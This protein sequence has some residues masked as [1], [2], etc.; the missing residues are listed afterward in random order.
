[1]TDGRKCARW[2]SRDVVALNEARIAGANFEQL[3]QLVQRLEAQRRITESVEL[4]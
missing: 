2:P 3:R 1:V 4:V